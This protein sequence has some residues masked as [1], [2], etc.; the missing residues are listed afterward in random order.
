[1]FIP[2][3]SLLSRDTLAEEQPFGGSTV[4]ILLI[5]VIVMVAICIALYTT[6]LFLRRRR[7]ERKRVEEQSMPLVGGSRRLTISTNRKSINIY[8][9]KRRL[10]DPSRPDSP[11][12]V[13]EITITFPDEEEPSGKRKSGRVVLVR[14]GE[15]S[16][17]MEPLEQDAPP[18]YEKEGGRFQSIDLERVG[19]LKEKPAMSWN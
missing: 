14:V 11:N 4:M 2:V 18:M 1:M 13:P 6:L 9:E 5:I 10:V 12:G 15:T 19:G 17:G 3:R 16:I 7:R 8:D